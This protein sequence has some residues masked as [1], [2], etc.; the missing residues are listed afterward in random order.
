M[1]SC[2]CVFVVIRPALVID[3]RMS[4]SVSMSVRR[5]GGAAVGALDAQCPVVMLVCLR[6]V[7]VMWRDLPAL[8]RNGAL[9]AYWRE[10]SQGGEMVRLAVE[11]GGALCVSS[12]AGWGAVR[13]V[14]HHQQDGGRCIVC[15][16]ISRM[17]RD[18]LVCVCVCMQIHADNVIRE[19]RGVRTVDKLGKERGGEGCA[20][21]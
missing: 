19:E 15:I 2:M 1:A 9:W 8:R 13:C 17:K 16:I 3:I 18:G 4:V 21:S 5:G 14:Y 10:G 12:S 6:F 7:V 11:G 20:Y